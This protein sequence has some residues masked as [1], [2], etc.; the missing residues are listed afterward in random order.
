MAS[1]YSTGNSKSR[2]AKWAEIDGRMP[3]S[4][5][6]KVAKHGLTKAEALALNLNLGEWHH[7]S[8]FANRIEYY[9]P[10]TI[11]QVLDGISADQAKAVAAIKADFNA[12]MRADETTKGIARLIESRV[13]QA[14]EDAEW[15]R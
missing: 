7:S 1:T 14:W 2:R 11:A 8:T 5:L 10:E 4:Q 6:P 12:W 15:T 3:W 9:S 13:D